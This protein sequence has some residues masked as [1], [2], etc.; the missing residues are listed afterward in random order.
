MK[1]ELDEK[2]WCLANGKFD[3]PTPEGKAVLDAFADCIKASAPY[4]DEYAKAHPELQL[5]HWDAGYRQL[6]DF[7]KETCKDT[8][9]KALKEKLK[10]LKEKMRPMIYTLGFLK[11]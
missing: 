10:A 6:R 3:N 7:L 2:R 5:D 9:L 8:E 1:N 4:R 11:K